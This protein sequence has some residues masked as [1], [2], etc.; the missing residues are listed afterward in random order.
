MLN[1][2]APSMLALAAIP[3]AAQEP[4]PDT[5]R[6]APIVVSATRVPLSQ[7]ALPVAVMVIT[8]EQLRLRG[9]TTVADALNDVTSAY[10]A[11]SGSQGATTS[12]FL[13]GGES[14]YVKVLI[15]GVPANDPGG[16]F[17][18]ASLTT[19]N[20][21]RIEIVRGPASVI[22]G[23]DAVTGVVH[24]ITRRGVGP[25]RVEADVRVGTGSRPQG[26]GMFGSESVQNWDAMGSLSGALSSG[27][28]SMS[29]ARHYSTGLYQLNNRYQNNLLS[30]R[31]VF[32]PVEGSRCATMTTSTTIRRMAVAMSRT[33][34][35]IARKI[36]RSSASRS[37]DR[38]HRRCDRYSRS[39]RA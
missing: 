28:Y 24:V 37:S 38:C 26:G 23:A 10:V 20:V 2:L 30:G 29:L 39:T 18:F 13:R 31:Y 21:E 3:L 22:Y 32:M 25:Q 6:V 1:R 27:S 16:A 4:S 35:P 5:A 19:D 9:V 14:K 7:S 33:A 36:A 8:G 12:L 15:D 17:D 11:Q 34:T